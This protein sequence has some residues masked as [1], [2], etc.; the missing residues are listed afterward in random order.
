MRKLLS[1][2]FEVYL[3]DKYNTSYIDNKTEEKGDKLEIKKE[4]RKLHAVLTFK[5]AGNMECINRDYNS[6]QNMEKIVN[7]LLNTVDKRRP[8]IYCRKNNGQMTKG[9][10][11]GNIG[12]EKKPKNIKQVKKS[13][14]VKPKNETK[15]EIII[16]SKKVKQKSSTTQLKNEI[17][18]SCNDI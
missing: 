7:E 13:K 8:E 15:K 1:K 9:P 12:E 10:L 2:R 17:D 3:I 6:V 16:K 18:F 4:N 5:R 11:S 14:N